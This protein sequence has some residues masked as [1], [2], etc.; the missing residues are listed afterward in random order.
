MRTAPGVQTVGVGPALV[1]PTPGIRPVVVDLAAEQMPADPPHVLVLA[2]FCQALVTTEYVVNVVDFER[3]VV[4]P[5]LLVLEAEEHVV[6]DVRVASVTP[7]ERTDEVVLALHV[8]VVRA[9]K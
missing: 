9:E 8:H 5:G 1:Y 6:I 4:Q 7:V 3:E 2:E